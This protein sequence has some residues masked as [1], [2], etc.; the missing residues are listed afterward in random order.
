M[1]TRDGTGPFGQGQMTGRGRGMCVTSIGS[2]FL[3]GSGRRIGRRGIGLGLG[4][5]L[6]CLRYLT[7]AR[8]NTPE[9]ESILEERETMLEE[10]LSEARKQRGRA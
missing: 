6:G 1:P 3:S 10:A 9:S 5:G 7:N 8:K 2:R 4:L